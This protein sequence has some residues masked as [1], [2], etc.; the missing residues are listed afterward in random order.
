[1]DLYL[2]K[3]QDTKFFSEKNS[4][5]LITQLIKWKNMTIKF[6]LRFEEDLEQ[7]KNMA[8]KF[9]EDLGNFALKI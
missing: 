7:W 5:H 4:L 1:M 9:E 8:I 6:A 2:T 3:F